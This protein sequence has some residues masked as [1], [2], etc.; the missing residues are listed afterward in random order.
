M[1]V[2]RGKSRAQRVRK[3][4]LSFWYELTWLRQTQI[5]KGDGLERELK[6]VVESDVGKG[7]RGQLSLR[8]RFS[9][10]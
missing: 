8:T 7:P 2:R 4:L 6:G 10:E 3:R 9:R 1:L 5:R